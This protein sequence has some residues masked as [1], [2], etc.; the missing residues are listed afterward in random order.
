MHPITTYLAKWYIK[1]QITKKPNPTQFDKD[2]KPV[3]IKPAKVIKP[4]PTNFERVN[5]PIPIYRIKR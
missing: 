1:Q 2:I 5:I 3:P 4:R